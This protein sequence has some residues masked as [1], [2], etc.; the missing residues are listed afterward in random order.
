MDY[1]ENL[2]SLKDSI[3]GYLELENTLSILESRKENRRSIGVVE[4]EVCHLEKDIA[5]RGIRL[6]LDNI[7]SLSREEYIAIVESYREEWN[8][9][10]I[11]EAIKR[12]GIIR[13]SIDSL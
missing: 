2:E 1:R 4:R 11:E 3:G 12:L 6:V 8:S 7:F 9:R 13:E 10:D 5:T